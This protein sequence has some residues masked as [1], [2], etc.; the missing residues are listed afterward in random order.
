MKR[1][2][3]NDFSFVVVMGWWWSTCHDVDAGVMAPSRFGEVCWRPLCPYRHSGKE[4]AVRWAAV[5]A[6]L[7]GQEGEAEVPEI[8]IVSDAVDGTSVDLDDEGVG[9]PEETTELVKLVSQG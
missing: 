2:G 6:L 3:I 7:A 4:R 8:N 9:V 5:W 1:P